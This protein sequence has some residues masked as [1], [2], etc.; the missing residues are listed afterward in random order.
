MK[1][2]NK[3]HF[4]EHVEELCK[5]ASQKVSALARISPLMKFE[6]RKRI[7]N[8]II[9]SFFSYCPL[10]F[11]FYSRRLNNCIN[12]IHERALRIICQDYNLSFVELLKKDN[13]LTIHQRKLKLLVTEMFK[14]NIGYA[15]DIRNG[16]FEIDNR[17]YNLPHDFFN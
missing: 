16:I 14:V 12:H 7:V 15:P 5:N 13:L 9:T 4:E 8:F 2:D 3:L 10:L 11:M 6:Q 17:N 1:I